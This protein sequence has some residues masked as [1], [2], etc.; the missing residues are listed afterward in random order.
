MFRWI[1]GASLQFRVLALG[2]AAALVVFGAL[3]LKKIPVDVFPEFAPPVVEVQTEA[4]GLSA[5]E[6]QGLITLNLEELLSGVPW[7]ESIRSQSVTGLSSIV[8]T[9]KRGT[10]IMKARQMIQE[11][12]TLAYTL[13]NVAQPPVIL[14]PLSATSRFMMVGI[15]SDK[16]EQTELSLLTRWT[17]KPRLLG[18]PGVANVAIWGQRLRQMHV[19]IDPNRLRDAK[20]LQEDIIAAAGDALWVSPLT[21]LKGSSPGTGGWIDNR[22]QRLGVQHTMPIEAPEDM[23]KVPVASPSLLLS[24]KNLSLGEVTEVTFSHPPLIG[25]AVLKN[26]NGLMLVIEKFPS[27]NTLEVTRGVDQALA[28][29]SRGLPGVQIDTEKF[30]LASYVQDS[31]TNLTQAIAIGGI[32]AILVIG[33]FM[34]SWRSALISAVS[35]MVSLLAAVTALYLT[36]STINTMILAG[37]V[38]ALSVIIDDVVVDVD[39]LLDQLR[40]RQSEGGM[41]VMSVIFHSTMESQRDALYATLIVMLAVL[42]IFFMGGV[43][44]AFFEPLAIAY[45]LAVVASMVVALT[46]TP[47]LCLLML[48]KNAVGGHRESPIAAWLVGKYDAALRGTIGASRKVL[49]VAAIAV[50]AGMAVWPLL[51]QSLLPTFKERD[52]LVNWSTPPGTSHAET[53]RITTRVSDELR[54]LPGVRSVGAHVGR[55]VTGDQVVGINSSQIWIGLDPAADYDNT[56]ASIRATVGGYPGVS[57]SVQSY[58]RDKVSEVLTGAGNAIVVRIYGQKLDILNQKAEEVRQALTDVK[59]IVDLRTEGQVEEAQIKVNVDLDAAGRA[60]VKPG[61]VRRST[62]TVFAGL[63]VGYLFKEQKIYEVVVHGAPEARHSL[64]NLRDLWIEKSDRTHSRLGDIAKVSLVSTPTVLRHERIAPYVDVVANVAG[65]DAGSV[66]EEVED[67]L[68][69]IQF[70]LEYHPEVLGEAHEQQAAQQHMLGVAIASLIGIFLLLQACFHS[71]RLAI[72]AFVGLPAAIAGGVLA[73][74]VSGG[75]VSLG[76]IVGFLAVLGIAAR[77][78]VALIDHYQQLEAKDGMPFGFDLVVRGAR[79]RL[80]PIVTGSVAIIAVFLPILVARQVPG[81]EIVQPTAI[82][83]IGGLIASTLTTLFVMPVLYLVFGAKAQRHS[84]LGLAGA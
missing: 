30:R 71:W 10:D 4:I 36:G 74:L 73:V 63:T 66:A 24:G 2:V 80:S 49:P 1:I 53:H 59:G 16:V 84:D 28:E 62:A 13:P 47:A 68:E 70:P 38:I 3:Q 69:K 20:V 32:L 48:P 79:E 9:F 21:F 29:L 23:A 27:A 33:V 61:D 65:R 14:Q 51:G 39:T 75:V 26:G 31:I 76:S 60:N 19:Q 45:L 25:D 15:S 82:V 58:L 56:L 57:H 7:L 55:A 44:G 12:L 72:I 43:A 67:R 6:V 78:A 77:N 64:T 40:A 50:L 83:I 81:L 34:F 18:V 5:D 42:P 17:V 41:S 22:N 35:I 52:L 8:M 11:R 46:V 37:L 54:S